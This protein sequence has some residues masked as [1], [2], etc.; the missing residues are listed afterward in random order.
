MI[1]EFLQLQNVIENFIDAKIPEDVIEKAVHKVTSK[2]ISKGEVIVH[3]GEMKSEIYFVTSGLIRNYYIDI[4]GNDIT[5]FFIE[6]GSFC[7]T[8]I[9]LKL[10]PSKYCIEALEDCKALVIHKKILKELIE[11]NLYCMKV[12]MKALENS[13]RYKI[14]RESSFLLKSATE[15]YLDFRKMHPSLEERVYQSYIA[16]YLGITPVSL[17]RIRR[18]IKEES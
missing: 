12:Y 9:L 3:I 14:D 7:N 2:V 15:R 18:T 13:L 17:S 8:E 6:E 5:R 4:N 10:E 1:E 11:E 16:S